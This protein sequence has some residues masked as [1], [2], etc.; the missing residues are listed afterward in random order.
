M[1]QLN[2]VGSPRWWNLWTRIAAPLGRSNLR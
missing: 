2:G 1:T